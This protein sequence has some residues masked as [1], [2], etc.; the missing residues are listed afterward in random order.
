MA[1]DEG[2]HAVTSGPDIYFAPGRYR[3][4][5]SLGRALVAHELV[6]VAQQGAACIRRPTSYVEYLETGVGPE[7]EAYQGSIRA[8]RAEHDPIALQTAR[9]R[10]MDPSAV[11]GVSQAPPAM[12]RQ[13]CI[14]GCKD[15]S[16]QEERTAAA[17]GDAGI[18]A[19]ADAG[20][21]A[22]TAAG[23][24]SRRTA[25]GL[26]GESD[27]VKTK[28]DQLTAGLRE[29]RRGDALDFHR[30]HDAPII[31]DLVR[32]LGMSDVR[33]TALLDDWTWFLE[34]GPATSKKRAPDGEWHGR[35]NRFLGRFE[36]RLGALGAM[37]PRSQAGF[38][39]KNTP[40][41]VFALIHET[42][43]PAI[44]PAMLYSA[45]SKEGLVDRYIRGQVPSPVASER[46][47]E[48]E[49]A[50]VR[51]DVPV[52]GFVALGL[53]TVFTD[54]AAG[55]RPLRD[56]LPPGFDPARITEVARVNEKG[57]TVRSA[58]APDLRTGLQVLAAMLARRQALFR[59]DVAALG[60]A[61]P[62]SDELVYWTYVYYN[63]GPG[64]R[65]HPHPTKGGGFDTLHRHRPDSPIHAERRRL[66]DWIT[67]SD[68]PNA[69]VVLQSYRMIVAAGV[70]TGY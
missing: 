69:I 3:P 41:S 66:A 49:M 43:T 4:D 70:L 20:V 5:L 6:H 24:A 63:T 60:F 23:E 19:R 32:L 22:T 9:A 7:S 54:L 14:A 10:I 17:G 44:P 36:P 2:A 30:T 47:S 58:D 39:L 37:F 11:S 35:V 50:N 56:F 53:D 12:R 42:A 8:F 68:F 16:T 26:I 1:A 45:A 64:N 34:H 62:T 15:C 59:E 29:I 65:A 13:R 25:A 67:S 46:L 27:A 48:S 38:W 33:K 61:A 40:A 51:T 28:K 18:E 31:E 21:S 52:H 57:S 55:H